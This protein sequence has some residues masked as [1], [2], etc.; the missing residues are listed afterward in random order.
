MKGSSCWPNPINSSARS[1]LRVFG[2]Q[3][4]DIANNSNNKSFYPQNV[5]LQ[6]VQ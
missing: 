5:I 2:K 4:A 1:I 6:N 3:T